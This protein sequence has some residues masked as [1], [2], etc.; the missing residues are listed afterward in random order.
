[1][2]NDISER[3]T[4]LR[5]GIAEA[6]EEFDRSVDEITVIA[7]TKSHPASAISVALAAGI[8]NIG[9]SKVQEAER[10]F[11]LIDPSSA[12]MHMIGHLQSNKAKKAVQI[13]DVIQ[14]VDSLKLAEEISRH[15]KEL[16]KGIECLIEVNCSGE[17]QKYGIAPEK[18]LELVKQINGL[19]NI[20]LT[21]LMTIAPLSDDEDDVRD[22]FKRCRELFEQA[23]EITNDDFERLSM[24]MSNDFRLA[25]AEGSTMLRIGSAIFGEREDTEPDDP[26][27]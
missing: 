27:D 2:K 16:D 22:A 13:F 17:A 7:V 8:R 12:K 25:I 19:P 4:D 15:A 18:T 1:M 24:G 20:Y 10:K 5:G 11:A 26:E 21:G 3:I 23:K 14:S 6:C 9:E